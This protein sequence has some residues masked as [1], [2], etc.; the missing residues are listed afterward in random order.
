MTDTDPELLK[1]L[2]KA[3]NHTMT[4]DEIEAQ[5]ASWLRAFQPCEHGKVDFEQC[6]ECRAGSKDSK[7]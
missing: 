2:E 5:R 7:L 1:L 4:L 3:R 6:A